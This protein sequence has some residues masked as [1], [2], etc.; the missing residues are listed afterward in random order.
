MHSNVSSFDMQMMTLIRF[1][2]S[3]DIELMFNQYCQ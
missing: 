2:A 3:T 1:V